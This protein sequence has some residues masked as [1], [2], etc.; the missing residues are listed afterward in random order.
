MMKKRIIASILLLF[1]VAFQ[2]YADSKSAVPPQFAV[3]RLSSAPQIDGTIDPEEWAPAAM[4]S[5]FVTARHLDSRPMSMYMAYDATHLYI[6]WRLSY[7]PAGKK[8]KANWN[9]R[10]QFP[11]AGFEEDRIEILLDPHFGQHTVEK[12]HFM[13]FIN[14]AGTIVYDQQWTVAEGV[15][16]DWNL[17]AVSKSRVTEEFWEGECA[18][19]FAE[20]GVKE[21]SDDTRWLLQMSRYWSDFGS[22][23]TLSPAASIL[24]SHNAGA[25]M[26]FKE[27]VPGYQID[28]QQPEGTVKA[29]ARLHGTLLGKTT[30]SG[31]V[32]ADGAVIA[33][34]E[35]TLDAVNKALELTM[36]PTL[37]ESNLLKLRLHSGNT[38]LYQAEIPFRKIPVLPKISADLREKQFICM[39]RYLPYFEKAWIDLVDF[40]NLELAAQ[41]NRARIE[42]LDPDNSK[43]FAKELPLHS[44][45]FEHTEILLPG[46]IKKDGTY[47][48]LIILSADKKEIAREFYD[49]EY[50]NFPFVGSKAGTSVEIFPEFLPITWKKHTASMV[51]SFMT[52]GKTALFDQIAA[53]QTEPT[54]G[55]EIENLLAAPITLSGIIDGRNVQLESSRYKVRKQTRS[56]MEFTAKARLGK[57]DALVSNSLEYDG[58][59]WI[60]LTLQPKRPMNLEKLTLDIPLLPE[61]ATLMYE[62]SDKRLGFCAGATAPQQGVIWDSMQQPNTAGTFGNFKPMVWVG[63]EDR[64]LTWFAESD[65]YWS[66]DERQPALELVREQDRV[67]LRVHFVNK[68]FALSKPR[69]I[70]FGLQPSPSKP[71]PT[72]WRSWLVGANPALPNV[73]SFYYSAA[74][75]RNSET[76]KYHA[77]CSYNPYPDS[78]AEAKEAM[79]KYRN[80]GYVFLRYQLVDWIRHMLETPEGRVYR[81]EWERVWT[82][83]YTK[84][85]QD[86]KAYHYDQ[87]LKNVGMF[88]VYEDEAYLRPMC[89]LALDAG[90]LRP[91]GEIQAE[92]G[93]RGLR[94]TLRR[95]AAVW[96]ENGMPNYYAVHKSGVTMTPCHSFAAIS[97]D[98]EQRFLDNPNRDYIDNWPLDFI[99][100]HVMGRQF[101]VVPVFLSEVRLSMAEHG[102]EKVRQANRSL[103][104]LTLL[105]DIIT[106]HA[107]NVHPPT[108]ELVHR[109]KSDFNLGAES[110][111]FHPYWAEPS[112]QL[113]NCK[114]DAIKISAW[115]NA[116]QLFIVAAN[117]GEQ[118]L[119]AEIEYLPEQIGFLPGLTVDYESRQEFT[120]QDNRIQVPIPRHDFRILFAGKSSIPAITS[121]ATAPV[122]LSPAQPEQE[123]LP[124]TI[125]RPQAENDLLFRLPFR[126]DLQAF[127]SLGNG[128]VLNTRGT[129]S[130]TEA[131][132]ALQIGEG[133]I[134][135]ISYPAKNNFYAAEGTVLFW[136]KPLD[137]QDLASAPKGIYQLFYLTGGQEKNRWGLQLQ[138]DQDKATL[139]LISIRFPNR[140][141]LFLGTAQPRTW[142]NQEWHLIGLTWDDRE[143]ILYIDALVA[144]RKQLAEPYSQKDFDDKVIKIGYETGVPGKENSAIADLRVFCRKLSHQ[145]IKEA[146]QKH[147]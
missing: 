9:R 137:F 121:R 40:S 19:P 104:T 139:A 119:L 108:R 99:R 15:Q 64:G 124:E 117:L 12:G 118:G 34:S 52:L 48:F 87:Y 85:F 70:S 77:F 135:S 97:I 59:A 107:W 101:G 22:W 134:E 8:P 25:V 28:F 63:N 68:P 71:L 112:R 4:L 130:F 11:P 136:I 57:L 90:Y 83:S 127:S 132:N 29:T 53:K 49:Y 1:C 109:A 114:Q 94:E 13:V 62:I 23:T 5:G 38:Q 116:E 26:I 91:D 120:V 86:F 55:K 35:K 93:I 66:L 61:Q 3:P 56:N 78:Y 67:V 103:L 7:Y 122:R 146:W 84:S 10:D 95:N 82:N 45:K 92:F 30:F 115:K 100:A 43:I 79:D 46:L 141:D 41:V 14:A 21:I 126:G 60:E 6:A 140:K 131:Q 73:R 125:E 17:D 65:R 143:M 39:M 37:A 123:Q 32:L 89:D 75:S 76:S 81:G 145:E 88:T 138:R 42:L 111:R 58:F 142:K 72:G 16:K 105:H 102:E 69:T 36:S 44:S 144:A 106:W 27:Q 98:G 129:V 18:I 20:L 31:E 24:N 33:Q 96:I 54:V 110:V 113:F 133:G 147:P 80:Q 2:L 47:R 74:I 50:K 51:S 128:N